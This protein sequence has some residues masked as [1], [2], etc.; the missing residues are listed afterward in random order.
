MAETPQIVDMLDAI[1]A[2]AGAI[3]AGVRRVAIY[4]TGSGGVP[5]NQADIARLK[6]DDPELQTLLRIDQSNSVLSFPF[7]VIKD[8]ELGASTIG[9]F[10]AEAKERAKVGLR[11]GAYIQISSLAALRQAVEANGLVDHVE[12]WVA[13]WNLTRDEAVAY[14]RD[15]PSVKAVQWASPTSN[16]HT[17]VPGTNRN[18][19][20]ANVDLS[21]TR[22]DWPAPLAPR[23]G[24][25]PKRHP[26]KAV[27]KVLGRPHVKITATAIEGAIAS[28]VLALL[29]SQHVTHLTQAETG[30][31]TL[32]AAVLAGYIVP[33]PKS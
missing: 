5:W 32:A 27:K 24:P 8:I 6:H 29:H 9:T 2:N 23:R 22:A 17:L 33:G 18:L 12:Y 21:V 4:L 10:V 13:D 16:P 15:N 14:L 20:E 28:A 26:V 30:V 3:P 1:G 11:T 25:R 19:V 7:Y 31:I